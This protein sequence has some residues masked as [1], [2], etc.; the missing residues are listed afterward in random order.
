MMLES[1]A[2]DSVIGDKLKEA[3]TL[4]WKTPNRYS[5]NETG[6]TA[7][8]GGQRFTNGDFFYMRLEGGWWTVTEGDSGMDFAYHVTL[9]YSYRFFG[10]CNCPKSQGFSVRLVKD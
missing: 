1:Y 9:G 4:H 6:F 2:G 8:G 10:G 7:L 3:D 5:T